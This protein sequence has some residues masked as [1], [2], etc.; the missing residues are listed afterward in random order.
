MLTVRDIMTTDVVTVAPESTIRE[1]METLSTNHLSGAPVVSGNRVLGVISMSD[2][3]SFIVSVP[4]PEAVDSGETVAEAWE[5]PMPDPDEE[6]IQSALS[7]DSYD[8]WAQNADKL[9]DDSSHDGR[10]LFDQHTVEEAMTQEVFSVAPGSSV[11][12]AARLM[13]SHGIHRVMVMEGK[14][15]EGIVS[16]L[17]IARAVSDRGLAGRSGVRLDPK[18]PDPSPWID[19]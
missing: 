13:R 6:D 3:V 12:A 4:E 10:T 11:K 2:I 5:E 8:E 9:L 18:S 16:A 19:I 15:L 7:D 14:K 1:A 17:D